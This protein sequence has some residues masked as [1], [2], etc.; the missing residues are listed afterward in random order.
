MALTK[1][2]KPIVPYNVDRTKNKAG[3]IEYSAWLKIQMEDKLMNI[4]LLVTDLGNET[5]IPG[6]P[7][8]QQYNPT[9]DWAK[10]TLDLTTVKFQSTLQEV[11]QWKIDLKRAKT[12]TEILQPTIEEIF[13]D[14]ELSFNK[15][16]LPFDGPI[17]QQIYN[18]EDNDDEDEI[19]LLWTYLGKEDEDKI[20][21]EMDGEEIE[22]NKIWIQ[23]MKSI[24]QELVHNSPTERPKFVLPEAYTEYKDVF[25]KK[26][27]QWLSDWRTWDHTIDLKPDFVLKDCKVYLM[28]LEEQIKLNEFLIENLCKGYIQLSKSSMASP[29]FFVSKKNS[30]KLRP[31]QDY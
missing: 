10:W 25:D 17:L 3:A 14:L 2:K 4:W 30:N 23:V 12:P 11:L 5:I 16:P 6:L 29:F 13:E 20:Y 8:L 15:N 24:S 7:W 1:L 27:S 9:I 19:D 31:C 28:T 21:P 26:V 18:E 22:A